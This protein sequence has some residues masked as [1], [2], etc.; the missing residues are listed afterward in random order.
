M[1]SRELV[2]QMLTSCGGEPIE[3]GFAIGVGESPLL[4]EVAFALEA[5]E[6]RIQGTFLDAQRVAGGLSDPAAD[7]VAV[8]RSPADG[9]EDQ[10]VEGARE[11]IGAG[12]GLILK[13][14]RGG[15]QGGGVSPFAIPAAVATPYA[16]RL[17]RFVAQFIDGFIALA[18]LILVVVV[19]ASDD[20]TLN[21]LV[22]VALAW[23]AAYNFLA[24]GLPG[25]QSFGK[26]FL[27]MKVI[28][29]ASRAPCSYGQ[30][31]IRNLVLWFLGPLDWVFIFGERHQRLGDKLAGT[32]VIDA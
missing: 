15:W 16:S 9:F 19:T 23:A 7:G 12:H 17:K 21:P 18:P 11:Q 13:S 2:A 24:D 28:D 10:E 1:P 27:G 29:F 22:W 14:A 30:S 5:V 20:G 26:H 4:L 25:G 8:H 3:L 31:F 32:I 6:R